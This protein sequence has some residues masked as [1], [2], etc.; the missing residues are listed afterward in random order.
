MNRTLVACLCAI[1]LAAPA[2]GA[3]ADKPVR[4]ITVT[5]TAEVTVVPDICYMSFGATT[6]NPTSA[7]RGYADNAAVMN[8]ITEALKAKGLDPKDV[9]TSNLTITPQYRYEDKPSRRVFDGYLV[10]H[11]LSVKVRDLAKVSAV[12]DAAVGAGATEVGGVNFTVENPKRY[13]ADARVDALNAARVKAERLCATAGMKLGKPT[14]ISEQ[15]PG[16]YG[17]YAQANTAFSRAPDGMGES[18]DVLSPGATKLTHTVFV[19]Y[20]ME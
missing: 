7:I 20:E 5:G 19:T 16:S 8:A 4:T 18:G 10:S 17:Y 2:F 6:R 14:T 1:A 13:T 3:P 9:Q 11:T 12:L 15:E